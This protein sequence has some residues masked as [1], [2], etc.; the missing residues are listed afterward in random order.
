MD[1]QEW[2]LQCEDLS[3]EYQVGQA[4]CRAV[5]EVNLTLHKGEFLMIM[6]KS[7]AGK[8]TLIRMM[9]GL[10][11]PT[12]GRVLFDG[13]NV[14]DFSEK[15]RSDFHGKNTGIVFQD[16][17]LLEDFTLVENVALPGCLYQKRAVALER[18]AKLIEAMGLAEQKDRLPLEVSAGQRQRVALARAMMNHPELLFLDE[19]TGNLDKQTAE[20]VMQ[21]LLALHRKGQTIVMVTHE[22]AFAAKADRLITMQDGCVRKGDERT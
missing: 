11:S 9:D 18:A 21:I 4:P 10:L 12:K 22:E 1:H 5:R 20:D 2:T 3:K 14:F 15:K 13:E 7:G 19:P 6:G 8:S 17:R 16:S